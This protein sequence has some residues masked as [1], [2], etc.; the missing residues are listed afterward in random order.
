MSRA[1]IIFIAIIDQQS[2]YAR[3]RLFFSHF[4]ESPTGVHAHRDYLDSIISVL[5]QTDPHNN[6]DTLES[7]ILGVVISKQPCNIQQ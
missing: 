5:N 7:I 3:A 2:T 1:I 6:L 4:T